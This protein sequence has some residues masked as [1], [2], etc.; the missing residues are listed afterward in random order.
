MPE[1]KPCEV[2]GCRAYCVRGQLMCRGHWYAVPTML[3]TAVNRTW[4]EYKGADRN[5]RAQ[6]RSALAAYRAAVD[7]AVNAIS[8]GASS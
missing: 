2:P 7:A 3:R 6:S 8:K 4:R 5:D 1:A